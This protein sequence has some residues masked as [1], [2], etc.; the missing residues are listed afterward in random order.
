MPS[1]RRLGPALALLAFA[2]LIVSLDYNI[3]YV[4]LPAIGADLGFS[5]QS[6][7]VV[8]S[9]YVVA[10]GG[11]LLLGGRMS[12]LLGRRRMFVLGL[13]LY[14]VSS[15][16]GGLAGTQ[17]ALVAARAVQGLGG[18]VLFPATLSLINTIFAEGAARNRA[19]G[20]WATAG[21]V[22]MTLGSLLGGLLTQAFGWESVFFVN[23]PMAGLAIVLA[24]PLITPDQARAAHRRFDVPGA[25][26]GSIGVTALVFALVRGPEAGWGSVPVV[27]AAVLAAVALAA[28]I[29]VERRSRD[30]LMPL[31]L[32]ANRHLSAGMATMFLFMGTFGSLLYFQTVYFQNVH[33]YS[34]LQTGLAFVVPM[35]AVLVGSNAGGR[36]VTRLGVRAALTLGSVLGAAGTLLLALPMSPSGSFLTLVP[37][38]VILSLGQGVAYTTM[39]A[40]A[41]IGVA[42]EDQGI[43][44][45]MASTGQQVGS[46]V[47]LA[48]LVAVANAGTDGLTGAAL[49]AATSDGLRTAV[50]IAAAGIAGLAVLAT[51]FKRASTRHTPVESTPVESTPFQSTPVESTPVRGTPFE[52]TPVKGTPFES[53]PFESTPFESTPFESTPFESTPFEST[54]FEGT[55]ETASSL[56]AG[57]TSA[58][59][60]DADGSLMS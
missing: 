39:F 46:A 28:F 44:S 11:A 27:I 41:S 29:T 32:F 8:V 31:R 15:L 17:W 43:A 50:L 5:P 60:L 16:V 48:V 54:S 55:S 26:T 52:S 34:A 33:G 37:G 10:F 51:A 49:R 47:G 30:P 23:A 18:A 45:G 53:T 13:A 57:G 12:D 14:G 3:V 1:A 25:L 36:L 56:D 24:F 42:P 58:E 19:L 20:V 22:G 21:A 35:V 2:Q 6:L 59:R 9:A 4:A 38:L 7:Q 40:A